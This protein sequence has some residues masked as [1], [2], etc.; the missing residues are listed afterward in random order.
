MKISTLHLVRLPLP[1]PLSSH[2][3]PQSPSILSVDSVGEGVHGGRRRCFR[4]LGADTLDLG[5]NLPSVSGSGASP[6]L[7]APPLL[8]G[9][10]TFI[11]WL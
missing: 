5:P 8:D 2:P 3:N 1:G 6:P 7:S 4:S 10:E 11:F 9:N